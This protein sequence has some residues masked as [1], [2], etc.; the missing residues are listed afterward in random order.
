M[1]ENLLCVTDENINLLAASSQGNRIGDDSL[2]LRMFTQEANFQALKAASKEIS[3][4]HYKLDLKQ[5]KDIDESFELFF[6]RI[7][8]G[9]INIGALS[10]H[11]TEH[12]LQEHDLQLLEVLSSY[13]QTLLLRPSQVEGKS[14][15]NLL[16][17]LLSGLP[18]KEGK[19]AR[20]KAV[21]D[22]GLNDS[23]R[24]IAIQLPLDVVTKNGTYLRRRFQVEVP[25]AIV[26]I[27][28][29]F[30]IGVINETKSGWDSKSFYQWVATWLGKMDFIAG[31]SDSFCD[32]TELKEY[33]QEARAAIKFGSTDDLRVR[34]FSECWDSYVLANCTGGLPA[35]LLFPP[36]F[37]RVIEYNKTSSVDYVETLRIW[38]EEG[39][40]DSR[41]AARLFICRNSFLCRRERL[42]SLLGD[43]LAD[44]EERFRLGLCLRLYNNP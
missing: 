19:I 39:R 44:P 3:T 4:N 13:V 42:I 28:E 43:D 2:L 40:N 27:H 38:L 21:L 29:G 14:F 31:A 41:T 10:I 23:F 33:Y 5:I 22:F 26:L 30:L 35:K 9:N 7:F 37:Q 25:A 24:C 34:T 8:D 32:L 18:V 17:S 1:L 20:L 16:E 6:I 12:A 36:G 15:I 11:P